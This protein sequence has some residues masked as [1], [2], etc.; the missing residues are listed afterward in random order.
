MSRVRNF[1][2]TVNNFQECTV[3]DFKKETLISYG[4][5]GEEIG[6]SGTPHL[7]GY[8]QLTKPQTISAF[9]KK[10]Q[11]LGIKCALFIAK[12][13]L[14][15]NETYC[16]KED[17]TIHEWGTP[18]AAGTRTDLADIRDM[19]KEEKTDEDILAEYPGDWFRYRKSFNAYRK[20][21]E[22]KKILNAIREE[23][24]DVKLKPWQDKAI[25][26][27]MNQD[28]RKVLWVIDPIGNTGKSFLSKWLAA[29]HGAFEITSG[30]TKDIAF[31]Y[32]RQE[33]V[34]FDFSRQKEDFV[35]YSV[36]ED[37][38]NGR[39]F[40]PKY[41]SATIR[42]KPAKVI[43]FSNWEPDKSQL[44]EDRWDIMRI[45]KYEMLSFGGFKFE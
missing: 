2:V 3:E 39:I 13:T 28:D 12:G 44:S 45:T 22:N 9:Q 32:N 25:S 16:T 30:A 8:L 27:L 7:Q 36:I 40:S 5:L 18:K 41:E 20:I 29:M 33:I 6:E 34:V 1:C 38:K 42:F 4:I 43:V 37:F 24:K 26:K 11:K 17:G 23:M 10:L 14:E 35:N 19:I 21:C 15:Q 31:A